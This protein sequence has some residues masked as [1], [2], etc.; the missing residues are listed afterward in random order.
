MLMNDMGSRSIYIHLNYIEIQVQSSAKAKDAPSSWLSR[1]H[2]RHQSLQTKPTSSDL[3]ACLSP[4]VDKRRNL[5]LSTL[6]LASRRHHPLLEPFAALS[7]LV[8]VGRLDRDWPTFER[9]LLCSGNR[10]RRGRECIRLRLLGRLQ[11][12]NAH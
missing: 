2:R 8:G 5:H 11:L 10:A 1:S 12:L 4:W 3:S 7:V 6:L 9:H